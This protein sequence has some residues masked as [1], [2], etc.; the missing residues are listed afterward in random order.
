MDVC[1]RVAREDRRGAR[2]LSARAGCAQNAAILGLALVLGSA[3]GASYGDTAPFD[4]YLLLRLS[5]APKYIFVTTATSNGNLGGV[6]G[7]DVKCAA[8][9]QAAGGGSF[10][11]LLVD[12]TA[13]V[14]CTS[15]N[16]ATSGATEHKDWVLAAGQEYRRLGTTIVIGTTNSAGLFEAPLASAISVDSGINWWTGFNPDYTDSGNN[17]QCGDWTNSIASGIFGASNQTG[18]AAWANAFG[19]GVSG[20]VCSSLYR[21]VCVQQ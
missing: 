18:T 1:N 13:R 14:A 17:E 21:L 15:A 2:T 12:G 4:A 6:T 9:A 20:D 11:A 8:D 7:A 10:K 3:C 5:R 16:C 19:T